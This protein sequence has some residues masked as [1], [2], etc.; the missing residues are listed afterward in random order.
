M[1]SGHGMSRTK[2]VKTLNEHDV[3]SFG[4]D[5]GRLQFWDAYAS[6]LGESEGGS[7]HQRNIVA[8]RL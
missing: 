6:K 4:E 5:D 2:A 1:P 3:S 8:I 7:F